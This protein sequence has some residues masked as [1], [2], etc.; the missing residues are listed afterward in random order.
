MGFL[1]VVS[2]NS[3]I[4]RFPIFL[5]LLPLFS[6]RYPFEVNG[7]NL[8]KCPK[9]AMLD[10]SSTSLYS[11]SADFF[12]FHDVKK[13][14]SEYLGYWIVFN[15]LKVISLDSVMSDN[16]DIR[17]KELELK[18]RELLLKERELRQKEKQAELTSMVIQ[19]VSASAG[20]IKRFVTFAIKLAISVAFG[21]F[22]SLAIGELAFGSR[23]ST[24]N[25]IISFG[26]LFL[27]AYI[28]WIIV[29][30]I[31]PAR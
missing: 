16:Y 7:L 4:H 26:L 14:E 18:E 13:F 24:T 25:E 20:P 31:F 22:F 17:R 1:C 5:C 30:K 9:Y 6:L 27:G 3:I 15:T 28:G 29:N 2:A 23:H 11:I 8:R 10:F 12:S 21:L 19:G